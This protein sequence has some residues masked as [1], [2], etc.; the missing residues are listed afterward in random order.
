MRPNTERPITCEIGTNILVGTDPQRIVS[1]AALI[2]DGRTRPSA[3]P[4]K[5]DG[6]AAGRIVDILL[7]QTAA[8]KAVSEP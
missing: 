5:W 2:L 4:E 6:L 7:S 3:I 8:R 1:E